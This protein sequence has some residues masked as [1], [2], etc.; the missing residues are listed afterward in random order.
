VSP[1]A[2]GGRTRLAA[3][4]GS[5][6]A[7]SLS[8]AMHNAAF[9]ACGFDGVYVAFDV[10]AGGGAAVL[11]AARELGF[12]G[13]S[14]TMPLKSEVADLVDTRSPAVVALRA[15]NTV[16]VRGRDLHAESTDGAGFVDS[17]RL[18]HGVDPAGRRVVVLG[19]GGAARSLVLA[20]GEAGAA[21]VA[22]VNR[23]RERAVEAA[24][25]AGS[26]GRV[27]GP[28]AVRDADIV[29]HATPQGMG[30]DRSIPLDASALRPGQVVAD[31]VYHPRRTRL[32][33]AAEERGCTVVDGL[34]MLVHQGARQFT[35]WTGLEAPRPEMRRAAE[36]ALSG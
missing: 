6:V 5:P 25:L 26:A 28:E 27:A 4:V 31:L 19:A 32:L 7:H 11:A 18:D 8:P 35:L 36:D 14:V 34:G 29:V 13:L 16:V 17:L 2:P 12:V 23:T 9:A 15:A 22:V 1:Q 20:L 21:D 24:S 33:V 30:A 3:I 10:G